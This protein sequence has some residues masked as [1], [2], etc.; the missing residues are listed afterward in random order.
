M[1]KMKLMLAALALMSAMPFTAF[2]GEW[3]QDTAG[4]WY[5]NDDGSYP[6][7]CWQWID[8]NGDGISENYYFDLNGYCLMNTI[9]PDGYTVDENG[10]WVIDGIVQTQSSQSVETSVSAAVSEETTA[11]KAAKPDVSNWRG[12]YPYVEGMSSELPSVQGF[13]TVNISTGKYHGTPNVDGLL[14]ENT[15]YYSGDAAVLEANGYVRCK[16][17]GCR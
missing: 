9:T 11:T 3:K 1:K 6:S 8:S 7:N 14:P 4:W 13:W 15:K 16:K 5:Q 2:A 17:N 12:R 10:A